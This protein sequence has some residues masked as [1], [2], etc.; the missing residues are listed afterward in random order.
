M[1]TVPVSNCGQIGVRHETQMIGAVGNCG[2]VCCCRRFMR[3]FDPV[4]I[5]MAKEQNLFLNPTK[6]SGI[7]GRL[8]CCLNFEQKN[9]ED[10]QRKCPINRGKRHDTSLGVVKV[11]RS[12][13]FRNSLTLI[14]ENNEEREVCVDDWA[15][16]QAGILPASL[17]VVQEKNLSRS[18]VRDHSTPHKGEKP[19]RRQN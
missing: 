9:Y 1:N 18:P 4:T 13:F 3:T 16:L 12:N 2:Q 11:I 7:C 15:D 10:F 17:E 14:T 5:K 19:F 8:L 6:I